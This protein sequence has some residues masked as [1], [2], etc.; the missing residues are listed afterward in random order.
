MRES[1]VCIGTVAKKPYRFQE[2]G[3][4]VYS[5]EEL[6]YYLS[7]H[8][9]CYL[10]TL[11]RT[12]LIPFIGENLE[13]PKL[14]RILSKYDDPSKDQMKYFSAL[15]REGNYF[16]EDEIREILDD[17]RELMNAPYHRQCKWM[18]DLYNSSGCYMKAIQYYRE[19]LKAENLSEQEHG[20]L[21]HNLGIA[22]ARLFRFHDARISLL[23]AYQYGGEE[24]SLYYYYC[25]IALTT[26]MDT[27]RNE[28]KSLDISDLL[29]DSFRDRFAQFQ[30][31]YQYS[32]DQARLSRI[33]YLKE[34]KKEEEAKEL[35]E[36]YVWKMKKNFRRALERDEK[37]FV[38]NL[39]I[40]YTL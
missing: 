16:N 28:I 18:G 34:H 33:E 23:K 10:Y 12:D 5:Y 13:L 21:Y 35:G 27:A 31:D 2:T 39:P 7:K 22:Q 32:E 3:V 25:M 6:C 19:G 20:A 15:F 4:E 9:I 14:A 17:Y 37:M 38:T 11:P 1:I 40:S 24:E 30:E 36:I 29:V 26:D 8:M